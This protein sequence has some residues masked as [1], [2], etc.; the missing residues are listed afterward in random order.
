[1]LPA[2]SFRNNLAGGGKIRSGAVRML[3]AERLD[4]RVSGRGGVKLDNDGG[5][6]SIVVVGDK[7]FTVVI[8]A[9]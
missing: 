7:Q 6:T 4:T 9:A 2:G 5:A 1:M 3:S 8:G